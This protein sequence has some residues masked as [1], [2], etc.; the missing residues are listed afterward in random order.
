MGAAVRREN[1]WYFPIL[2]RHRTLVKLTSESKT[3]LGNGGSWKY[4]LFHAFFML[5]V[6]HFIWRQMQNQVI[7]LS[8]ILTPLFKSMIRLSYI[9]DATL[10]PQAEKLLCDFTRGKLHFAG[11]FALPKKCDRRSWNN[12]TAQTMN[13]TTHKGSPA[14]PLQNLVDHSF[15]PFEF[16]RCVFD[17]VLG[18][19]AAIWRDIFMLSF[20]VLKLLL[21]VARN[22]RPSTNYGRNEIPSWNVFFR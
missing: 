12:V 7:R 11:G 18:G 9:S 16:E 2:Y 21:H 1:S 6:L 20:A 8:Y 15:T 22:E 3:H 17:N 4:M 5:F 13:L 19:L 14:R 10:L